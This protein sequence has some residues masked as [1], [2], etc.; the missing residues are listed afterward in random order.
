V[1]TNASNLS[2][3]IGVNDTSKHGQIY[4]YDDNAVERIRIYAAH[5]PGSLSDKTG[6]I[7]LKDGDT[8]SPETMVYMGG[9]EHSNVW[10]GGRVDI[11]DNAGNAQAGIQM[12]SNGTQ[13]ETFGD[14]K[15]FIVDHPLRPDKV[16][17]YTSLEGSSVDMYHR[18]TYELVDGYAEILLPEHF[19]LLAHPEGMSANLTPRSIESRGLAIVALKPDRLVV[20]EL[21]RGKGNYMFDYN[22]IAVRAGHENDPII[23][24]WV[25]YRRPELQE[26][27][28]AAPDDRSEPESR[29]DVDGKL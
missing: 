12:K 17:A 6:T 19:S 14:T 18:G 27:M 23:R 29:V 28:S 2:V 20:Q 24:D 25:Q 1:E 22:V 16:I 10:K 7:V 5:D 11:R 9:V 13:G 26:F 15:S 21:N 8:T 4:L 3:D